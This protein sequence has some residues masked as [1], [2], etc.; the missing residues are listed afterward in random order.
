V[1]SLIASYGVAQLIV[2]NIEDEVVHRLKARAATHGVSM[3]EEHRRLLRKALLDVA[4]GTKKSF[5]EMLLSI[6]KGA[7]DEPE[8]LFGRQRDLPRP[9]E[10]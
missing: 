8:N 2:G 4:S 9:V 3:E 10:L 5:S 1:Q 7:E 6:P